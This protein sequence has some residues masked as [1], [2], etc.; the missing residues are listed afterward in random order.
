M[1]WDRSKCSATLPT[2]IEI[3]TPDEAQEL[4]THQG[5]SLSGAIPLR[6]I[7]GQID[8]LVISGCPGAESDVYDSHFVEWIS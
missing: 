8:T 4:R 3:G 2:T 6:E 7:K 5:I 1:L